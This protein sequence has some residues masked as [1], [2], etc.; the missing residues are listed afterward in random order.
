MFGSS[1]SSG[2]RPTRSP[3]RSV[4]PLGR[5]KFE[6]SSQ[7]RTPYSVYEVR[8]EPDFSRRGSDI[9]QLTRSQTLS[10]MHQPR[11]SPATRRLYDNEI[12]KVDISSLAGGYDPFTTTSSSHRS[13]T[14]VP[15][16]AAYAASTTRESSKRE[17]AGYWQ[18]SDVDAEQR[19]RDVKPFGGRRR[20]EDVWLPR[21][22][23]VGRLEL[24]ERY[25]E[26][27][28]H[29]SL[30]AD[31]AAYQTRV[32]MPGSSKGGLRRSDAVH[33]RRRR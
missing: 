21:S 15:M 8:P 32:V 26:R 29:V 31:S 13:R 27:F 23:R 14:H 22:L 18:A 6:G 1:H 4:S 16:Y 33:G 25:D 2:H 11:R 17:T 24:R 5:S 7:Y 28:F 19:R 20:G 12:S 3:E 9:A 30:S 10:D